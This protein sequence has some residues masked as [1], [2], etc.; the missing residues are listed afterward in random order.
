MIPE[1]R[2]SLMGVEPSGGRNMDVKSHDNFPAEGQLPHHD[3]GVA[4]LPTFSNI[5]LRNED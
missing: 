4:R 2:E 1:N 3:G 5:S